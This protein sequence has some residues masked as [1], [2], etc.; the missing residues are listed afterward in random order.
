MGV[1]VPAG[2][3]GGVRVSPDERKLRKQLE[4]TRQWMVSW[5]YWPQHEAAGRCLRWLGEGEEA[6]EQFRI[7]ARNFPVGNPPE[8][9]GLLVAGNL[10]RLAGEHDEA[11]ALFSR[12]RDL[13][14]AGISYK[15]EDQGDYV[16]KDLLLTDL[17]YLDLCCFFLGRYEEVEDVEAFERRPVGHQLSHDRTFAGP[18]VLV[19]HREDW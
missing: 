16:D 11:R 15:V 14:R 12:G 3:G 5:E 2:P 10:Y 13:L 9:S 1:R 4:E 18:W 8:G 6:A 19:L 7:A 17:T